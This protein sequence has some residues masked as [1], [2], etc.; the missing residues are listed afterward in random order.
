MERVANTANINMQSIAEKH[1]DIKSCPIC[2]KEYK[3]T[4]LS[5]KRTLYFPDC[6]CEELVRKAEEDKIA[7]FK[8]KWA[9]RK[10]IKDANIPFIMRNS[11]TRLKNLDCENLEEAKA[12]VNFFRPRRARGFHYVGQVGNGKTTLAV[13]IAKELIRKGYNVKFY[14][15]SQAMR[16]LQSSYSAKNPLSFDEQLKEFL[17]VDLL[18]F[19]DFGRDGYK[20]QKLADAFEFLNALYNNRNNVILTSNPE[21][22]EKV[23][24]I[25]DFMAMLDRFHKMA[26]YRGFAKPSYRRGGK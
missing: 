9:M 16:I 14:T 4:L 1:E 15:F 24:A 8:A 7:R 12:Y 19:D 25:P 6:K 5:N 26:K 10:K 11:K 17:K 20:E 21:M 3:P 2:G 23:K 13:A 22:I 18:I